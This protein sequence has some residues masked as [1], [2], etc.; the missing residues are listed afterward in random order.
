MNPR[1]LFLESGENNRARMAAAFARRQA[2]GCAEIFCAALCPGP[3]DAAAET[4]MGEVGLSLVPETPLSVD[5]LYRQRFDIVILMSAQAEA[6]CPLLPG[7]PAVIR[8][9]LVDA[10]ANADAPANA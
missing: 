8:W 9:P 4:V 10:N 2:Q 5:A 7:R 6:D 3:S 1:I